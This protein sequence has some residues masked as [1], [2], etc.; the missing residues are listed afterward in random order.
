MKYLSL[1]FVLA[2][3]SQFLFSQEEEVETTDSI[4]ISGFI[5]P[6]VHTTQMVTQSYFLGGTGAIFLD[7]NF[8]LGGFGMTMTNYYKTDRGK[9]AGNELDM[10]GFGLVLGYVF[11]HEKKI[12]PVITLWGGGG[13]IS[14]SDKDKVR[15]KDAFDDFLW[16][17]GTFEIE[18]RPFK[19]MSVGVGVHYQKITGLVLDGYSQYDFCGP[20]YYFNIKMGM[21]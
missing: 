8:F 20:G 13:S 16:M 1:I 3:S 19:F 4:A 11:F 15:N 14:L 10:G 17:N 5:S 21:F 12:H 7:K 2:L 9:Y 6:F 18:Y